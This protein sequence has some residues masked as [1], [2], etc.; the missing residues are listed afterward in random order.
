MLLMS[1]PSSAAAFGARAPN[2]AAAVIRA[3]TETATAERTVERPVER[4][5]SVVVSRTGGL[6]G[7]R[8]FEEIQREEGERGGPGPKG[9]GPARRRER[10][11]GTVRG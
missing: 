7:S 4:A 6:S 2:S 8:R 9:W 1:G 10:G 3:A 5:G 11:R